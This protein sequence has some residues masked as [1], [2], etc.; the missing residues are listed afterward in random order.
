MATVDIFNI[1]MGAVA[2]SVTMIQVPS[3]N[4]LLFAAQTE[5]K[6]LTYAFCFCRYQGTVLFD[7]GEDQSLVDKKSANLMKLPTIQSNVKRVVMADNMIT[8][9]TKEAKPF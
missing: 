8:P 1:N 9:V 2:N 7:T 6:L 5:N 4:P 3:S